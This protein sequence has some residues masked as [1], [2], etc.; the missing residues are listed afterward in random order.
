MKKIRVALAGAWH[1]HTMMYLKQIEEQFGE[2]V[3]WAYVWDDDGARAERVQ[4]QTGAPIAPDL[5]T[6][7]DDPTVDAVLCEAE[8]CK[9][10]DILIR[11]ARAGKH[12]YTD[13]ALCPTVADCLAVKEAIEQARVKFAVSH[14]SLAVASYRYAKK[15]VDAGEIGEVV[16]LHFR[17]AHGAAKSNRLP[18]DW[19]SQKVA[20]GGALID[21]GIHGL[22]ML[23]HFCGRPKSVSAYTHNFTGHETEDSATILVEFENGA[24]G[25]AHTDMVTNIMENNFEILG[26]DGIITIQGLEG[27][28]V[29]KVNSKHMPGKE[30]EM[31]V[32]PAGEYAKTPSFPVCDFLRF[33]MTGADEDHALAGMDMETAL[34]VVGLAEAAYRSADSGRAIPYGGK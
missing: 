10:R 7:L 3:A 30:S 21:L 4:K 9:H 16:S 28:D 29:V 32:V 20:G 5:Q 31:A 12:V 8:T 22:S 14:E 26:T 23:A 33:V 18:D 6:I 1:V 25:T 27:R 34:A 11:A 24:I 13:K 2:S 15:L 19:F 17:R